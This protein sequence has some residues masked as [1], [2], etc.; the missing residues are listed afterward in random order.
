MPECVISGISCNFSQLSRSQGQVAHVLLTRSP[1][2]HP[3]R[4]FT[5]RL[6]CVKHAASVRPE[7]G[8]NS[9]LMTKQHHTQQTTPSSAA[10]SIR[11]TNPPHTHHNTTTQAAPQQTTRQTSHDLAQQTT[12]QRRPSITTKGTLM[13][14]N[15]NP[16]T[17]AHNRPQ[18]TS[19]SQHPPKRSLASTINTLL[20][21]QGTDA[22]ET[23]PQASPK[24]T[25]HTHL[26]LNPGKPVTK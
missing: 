22:Q 4:G 18:P 21:S 14:T 3:R 7:P 2:I 17:T 20:S 10:P 1:L 23:N 12:P 16:Q 5:V 9:P 26:I 19:P 13:N 25:N 8:S 6:A 15:H 11:E 24:A